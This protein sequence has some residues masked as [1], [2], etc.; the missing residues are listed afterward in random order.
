MKKKNSA[1]VVF[2]NVYVYHA[3]AFMLQLKS[4]IAL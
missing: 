1:K 2:V 4:Y 3:C